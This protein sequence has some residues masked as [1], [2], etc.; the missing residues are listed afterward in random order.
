MT[1][2]TLVRVS[3]LQIRTYGDPVLRQA[4]SDVEDDRRA[5]RRRSP[6]R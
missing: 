6:S 5:R 3:E 2:G 1:A 4:T